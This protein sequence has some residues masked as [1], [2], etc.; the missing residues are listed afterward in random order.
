MLPQQ[1]FYYYFFFFRKKVGVACN[2]RFIVANILSVPCHISLFF[3][4]L[5]T[6]NPSLTT[7]TR[8]R[9]SPC[10][11]IV[12]VIVGQNTRRVRYYCTIKIAS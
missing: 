5:S 6:P 12:S 4:A 8:S 9:C 11:N 2:R 7:H 1:R 3:L 10:S